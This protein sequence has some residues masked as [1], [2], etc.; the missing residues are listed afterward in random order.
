M[1]GVD[2]ELDDRGAAGRDGDGLHAAQRRRQHVGEA[3]D[4]VEDFP[5]HMER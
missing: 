4:A 2:L 1:P 3:V 5:D